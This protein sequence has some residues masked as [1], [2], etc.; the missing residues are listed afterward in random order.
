MSDS[1]IS[2]AWHLGDTPNLPLDCNRSHNLALLLSRSHKDDRGIA[3]EYLDPGKVEI[4]GL[5][6]PVAAWQVTGRTTVTSRSR[7][8]GGNSAAD[9]S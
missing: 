5:E 9:R 4:K 8:R 1:A 2:G 6:E 3:I 7:S